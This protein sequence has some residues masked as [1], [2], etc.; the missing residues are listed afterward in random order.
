LVPLELVTSADEAVR[1]A[2]ELGFP[3]AVKISSAAIAH[4]SE[5][6]AVALGLRDEAEVAA[7]YKRVLAAAGDTP[8][9]G[10]TVSA[11]RSGGIELL[12][13][14]TVDPIFGPVLAVGLGGIWVEVLRDVSL[15]V[16][17]TD[18]SEVLA[19]LGELRGIELLRGARGQAAA[20]LGQLASVI[21]AA[22]EAA[23][24]LGSEL[25][26]LEINP[27]WVNGDQIEALDVLVITAVRAE[28]GELLT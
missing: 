22:G 14:V 27:L 4:K 21:A 17:P 18:R 5:L 26:S 25:R 23:L 3:V 12:A 11:M 19:M 24:S 20:D 9:D 13:G 8:V 28:N 6:G 7:A 1:A 10:V 15:R 2:G 16:L